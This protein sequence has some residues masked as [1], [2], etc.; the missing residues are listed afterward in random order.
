MEALPVCE[1][2]KRGAC[3][4]Q[5]IIEIGEEDFLREPR[6]KDEARP[7]KAPFGRKEY[8]DDDGKLA[9]P[10]VEGWEDGGW[11]ACGETFP[12]GMLAEDNTCKIYPNSE[13]WS[14]WLVGV[15][16][17]PTVITSDPAKLS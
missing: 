13:R 11:L 6:L 17:H 1:C 16:S 5:L 7:L 3:C 8:S 4:R 15:E 12:W 10:L 9:L 14:Q 2:D